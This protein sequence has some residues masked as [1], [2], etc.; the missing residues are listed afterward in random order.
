MVVARL[1]ERVEAAHPVPADE[2]VLDRPVEGVPHVELARDVR[3]RDADD[4]R[5]VAAR[6][7]AR[8]VEA[9]G[10]PRLLP[11]PL[12]GGRVVH[13]LPS[14]DG[15]Y[16]AS[17]GPVPEDEERARRRARTR[18][19]EASSSRASACRRRPPDVD[20]A[21]D[22]AERSRSRRGSGGRS[23][24]SSRASCSPTPSGSIVWTAQPVAESTSVSARPPCTTPSGLSTNSDASPSNTACAVPDLGEP[25]ARASRRSA[26]AGAA[27]RP[28]ACEV[29]EPARARPRRRTPRV[30][31][32]VR[33]RALAHDERRLSPC[34]RRRPRGPPRR[35]R[36]A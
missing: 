12:D 6:A 18:R 29:R 33:P 32:R 3:R 2:H 15:V 21:P 13:A 16:G 22:A 8:G 26:A 23:S 34:R 19:P 7:G 10:L 9:L 14:G 11:A 36:R 4:E 35:A 5:V 24:P 17:S 28:C 25:E 31:P 27:P 20:G 30:G 1:P